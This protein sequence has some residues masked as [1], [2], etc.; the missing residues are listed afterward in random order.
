[1]RSIKKNNMYV[2]G[3]YFRLRFT[4]MLRSRDGKRGWYAGYIDTW[5]GWETNRY[6]ESLGR[7]RRHFVVQVLDWGREID[8]DKIEKQEDRE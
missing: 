2:T 8:I 1:C 4:T 5:Q 3:Y 6:Q 7:R